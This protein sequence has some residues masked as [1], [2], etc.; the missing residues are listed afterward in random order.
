MYHPTTT[1][2]IRIDIKVR[3]LKEHLNKFDP[4]LDVLYYTE[5]KKL[6]SEPKGFRLLDI[7]YVST[8]HG[9]LIHIKDSTPYLK[10]GSGPSSIEIVTLEVT[11]EF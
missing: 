5:D 8:N 2:I 1:Y 3:E 6:V 4:E 9:E 7:E 10:L 11:A